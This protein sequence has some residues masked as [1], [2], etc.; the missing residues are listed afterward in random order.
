[1]SKETY[2]IQ[3]DNSGCD[4]STE[5]TAND[6]TALIGAKCPKCQGEIPL[7]N[8]RDWG[9]LMMVEGMRISGAVKIMESAE[10]KK[11]PESGY[12]QMHVNTGRAIVGGQYESD[13]PVAEIKGIGV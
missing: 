6:T 4:Y 12:V 3:C 8:A 7:L 13:T 5:S 1:M 9:I 11:P 2:T 10:A